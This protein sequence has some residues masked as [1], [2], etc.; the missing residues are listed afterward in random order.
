MGNW[1]IYII[2]G[3]L[4]VTGIEYLSRGFPPP[5]R[6]ISLG[7]VVLVLILWLLS[8]LGLIDFPI[9]TPGFILIG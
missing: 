3:I 9:S 2:I 4:L 7:I 5:W 8:L 6:L 1:I